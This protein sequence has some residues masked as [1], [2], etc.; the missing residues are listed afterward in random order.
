MIDKNNQ[1]LILEPQ[2]VWPTG[3]WEVRFCQPPLNG[4]RTSY[5]LKMQMTIDWRLTDDD[6]FIS[7]SPDMPENEATFA[8]T[9]GGIADAKEWI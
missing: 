9:A 5:P 2:I 6:P 1:N 8:I 7:S 4:T 3:P